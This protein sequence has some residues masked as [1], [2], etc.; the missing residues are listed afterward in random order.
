MTQGLFN[1]REV[2][3]GIWLG[4]LLVL[5]LSKADFRKSLWGVV[6]AFCVRRI[7]VSVLVM[8]LYVV[9]TVRLLSAVGLWESSLLKDTIVWFCVVAMS[10][11]VRFVTSEES[12][13][14]FAKV[15]VEVRQLPHRTQVLLLRPRTQSTDFHDIDHLLT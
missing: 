4:V 1:S 8:A 10:M 7:L 15:L 12:E 3:T 6:R 2:A 9:A 5:I 13:N 14:I 11:M